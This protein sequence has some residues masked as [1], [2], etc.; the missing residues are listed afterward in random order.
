MLIGG[1]LIALMADGAAEAHYTE[2]FFFTNRLSKHKC[3]LRSDHEEDKL[4]EG[5]RLVS[6]MLR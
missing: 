5:S 2:D 6:D 1:L 4:T 3:H